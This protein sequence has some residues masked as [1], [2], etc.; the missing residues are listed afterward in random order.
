MDVSNHSMSTTVAD[1]CCK[2]E[3]G[4]RMRLVMSI[5]AK[6]RRTISEVMMLLVLVEK[7]VFLDIIGSHY[8]IGHWI[9][10]TTES[11]A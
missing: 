4:F 5:K 8:Y 2:A 11:V 3:R 1:L 9:L 6:V 7:Q 10:I